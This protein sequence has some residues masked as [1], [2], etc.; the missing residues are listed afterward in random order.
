M[1]RTTPLRLCPTM[2]ST[3]VRS[4][5]A[6]PEQVIA[7][8]VV[9]VFNIGKDSQ[10]LPTITLHSPQRS[11]SKPPRL[12]AVRA[13]RTS[14]RSV[15]IAIRYQRRRC[16]AGIN[17]RL[18]PFLLQNPE[19]FVVRKKEQVVIEANGDRR[20]PDKSLDDTWMFRMADVQHVNG[21]R[22]TRNCW[23]AL[24]IRRFR[25]CQAIPDHLKRVRPDIFW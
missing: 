8:L 17:G 4:A 12:T 18:R 16:P 21:P 14:A 15:T 10:A 13:S 7:L 23:R 11:K 1:G 3:R 5:V 9:T 6:K 24:C 22:N 19:S 2:N 20:Y 25:Q